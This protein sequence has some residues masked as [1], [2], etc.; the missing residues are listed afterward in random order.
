MPTI[1][2]AWW[3]GHV[4]M[5]AMT[6]TVEEATWHLEGVEQDRGVF[7]TLS[8]EQLREVEELRSINAI[9]G[10]QVHPELAYGV[11]ITV[12]STP[13]RVVFEDGKPTYLY[14]LTVTHRPTKNRIRSRT[15]CSER[16]WVSYSVNSKT[17]TCGYKIYITEWKQM[18]G[19]CI[20]TIRPPTRRI[21]LTFKPSTMYSQC[22][23]GK[24]PRLATVSLVLSAIG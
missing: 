11:H 19:S 10:A 12:P 14:R 13:T 4:K 16:P 3:K 2:D 5:T 24:P 7:R 6:E 23:S 18:G 21:K 9:M 8:E 22:L 15:A 20:P 1:D 17:C